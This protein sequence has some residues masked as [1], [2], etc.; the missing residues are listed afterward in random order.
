MPSPCAPPF[1][2]TPSACPHPL[3]QEEFSEHKNTL[4]DKETKK[5]MFED[6][7]ND[8]V[9]VPAEEAKAAEADMHAKKAAV[10]QLKQANR[11]RRDAI[12]A[13]AKT[14]GQ[15]V[16]ALRQRQALLADQYK[17][18]EE[19]TAA[20]DEQRAKTAAHAAATAR[21]NEQRAEADGALARARAEC[22]ALS[23]R[24]ASVH[25][26]SSNV[27][28]QRTAVAADGDAMAARLAAADAEAEA[29]AE[30]SA[31]RVG[32]Y[33]HLNAVVQRLAGIRTVR[34]EGATVTYEL[35]ASGAGS[36]AGVGVSV[37][38]DAAS[39][40][41][42][43]ASLTPSAVDITD[44]EAYAV[45][46]NSIDFLIR[47]VRARLDAPAAAA[48][49]APPHGAAAPPPPASSINWLAPLGA[50]GPAPTPRSAAAAALLGGCPTPAGPAP[51]PAAA[52]LPLSSALAPAQSAAAGSAAAWSRAANP[53]PSLPPSVPP[54]LPPSV[55]PSRV[56]A[57]GSVAA[58]AAPL[59]TP[60]A[61]PTPIS[62]SPCAAAL[63]IENLDHRMSLAA[64]AA[65]FVDAHATPRPS[66]HGWSRPSRAAPTPLSVRA[67]GADT[68]P[69]AEY[70]PPP[71]PPPSHAAPTPAGGALPAG[72]WVESVDDSSVQ[73]IGSA[74]HDGRGA[75][76]SQPRKSFSRA[77]A[78]P[79]SPCAR[80]ARG[81]IGMDAK[82]FISEVSST[83]GTGGCTR[84]LSV[85]DAIG[86]QRGSVL[87]DGCVLN[88]R[89]ELVGY[90]E[91]DG[92][93]GAP[94]LSYV[95]PPPREPQTRDRGKRR[96][97]PC[98]HNAAVGAAAVDR[99][100]RSPLRTRTAS[101]S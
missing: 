23:A 11:D 59:P 75:R 35:G 7:W 78:H 33:G 81:G 53:P 48:A 73:A 95:R 26:E 30:A 24:L 88:A 101:G 32:W 43:G 65:P 54:S 16:D 85:Y 87:T 4:M 20:A 36:G 90:V 69:R 27:E 15:G 86:G 91:A 2:P 14:L 68:V 82:A 66:P 60:C 79:R 70:A 6:L 5:R 57:S 50:V 47:E 31:E 22:D 40:A 8:R 17:A 55:P 89:G 100:A 58:G 96:R 9:E 63:P 25:K 97:P 98:A 51:T 84:E 80:A 18:A 62:T 74:R 12:V 38:F 1:P 39:G 77:V 64:A 99:L 42:L 3:A 28:Q 13:H 52:G 46:T 10:Q 49:A 94:D 44:L 67:A 56:A 34:A 83:G 41:L 93:V 45:C 71:P 76:K 21:S 61:A 37:R 92:T 72:M 29:V 19:A